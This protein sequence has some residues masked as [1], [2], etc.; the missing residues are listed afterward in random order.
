MRAANS[1][2]ATLETDP[3]FARIYFV[4]ADMEHNF[5]QSHGVSTANQASLAIKL[6]LKTKTN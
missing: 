1:L 3:I 5:P 2:S 6:D 4:L